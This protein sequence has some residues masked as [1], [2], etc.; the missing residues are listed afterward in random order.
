MPTNAHER[1]TQ[2]ALALVVVLVGIIVL[3]VVL[4]GRLPWNY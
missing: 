1:N 2:A 4:T 3:V